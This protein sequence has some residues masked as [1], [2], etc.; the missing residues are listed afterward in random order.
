MA[1][2]LRYS[3]AVGRI[4][5]L[6]RM[7]KSVI[8]VGFDISALTVAMVSVALVIP[9]GVQVL[10]N[11][12]AILLGGSPLIV[13]P[14][15]YMSG[16]YDSFVRFVSAYTMLRI[17][18]GMIGGY[19][20]LML[21]MAAIGV[22][23]QV[24]HL[25]VLAPFAVG[26]MLT[27]WR[28]AAATFLSPRTNGDKTKRVLIYGAGNA[29]IQL[30]AGLRTNRRYRPV[31]FIDDRV[32][33]HGRRM[34]GLNVYSPDDLSK[35]KQEGVFERVL[36]AIPSA[37]RSR[38]REILEHLDQLE[39]KVLV[40]PTLDELVAGERRIDELR[41]VQIEDLLGRDA[42]A[43]IQPLMDL[44][45][46]DKTVM[47][48]GAGGSI[49]SELCRQAVRCGARKLVL[50][51]MCEFA[52]YSIERELRSLAANY[53]CE[54][55]PMLG[56][57]CNQKHVTESLR[58]HEVQTIYHAAAYK[59]VPLVERN[60]IFAILNN[61]FG[62][63]SITQAA[64]AAGVQ[65]FVLVSTDKAVRPT[66]V[67][68]ASKRVCELVV[69]ALAAQGGPMRMSMVRFGNVLASSGSV[70]PLF[71]EQIRNGG[72]ITVTHP[73][74]T[75]YFMTILEAAQLVIQAGAMGGHGEVFVLDMGEPVKI[76]N[77]AERMIHLSG[78]KIRCPEDPNGDV[79]IEFTGL[80]AGEKLYEELLIG[81]DPKK[82]EHTRIFLARE[83]FVSWPFLQ[84]ALTRLRA[85]IDV[86]ATDAAIG[87]LRE[88][89]DGFHCDDEDKAKAQLEPVPPELGIRTKKRF[90]QERA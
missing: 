24:W 12:A 88:L 11:N 41:E 74:V 47:V 90:A 76:R 77:L 55:V 65:N 61:V 6:P 62:T 19:A 17:L 84:K 83:K 53:Q 71:R 31:G 34:F 29:G 8:A 21:I 66:S 13:I 28:L 67:M 16:S 15:L 75:R 70:V 22:L 56:N 78:L 18:R 23:P 30:A 68:G 14:A 81:N 89:V 26:F 85:A 20:V 54:V 44:Y 48:T 72:P 5:G 43:P 39:I 60:I 49:G 63:L 10:G 52:L 80:R 51:D 69:Q 64:A 37:T 36:L 35:L 50:F 2:Q 1:L 3:R 7:V 42:V 9:G 38:R 73:E 25:L 87:E 45:L 59:H 86:D 4:L 46:K 58:A 82:T 40:M 57:V 32:D 33:Y 27:S 79:A